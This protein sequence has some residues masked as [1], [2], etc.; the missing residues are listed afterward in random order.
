MKFTCNADGKL[1]ENIY[2]NRNFMD[3]VC[4]KDLPTMEKRW[5]RNLD[6]L[7]A[8]DKKR[9]RQRKLPPQDL[10]LV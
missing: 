9:E 4:W 2:L 8:I 3:Y 6:K 1:V 5:F 7:L 10:V